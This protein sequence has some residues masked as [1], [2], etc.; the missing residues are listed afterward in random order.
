MF[1]V[2]TA[3]HPARHINI[4]KKV[5]SCLIIYQSTWRMANMSFTIFGWSCHLPLLTIPFLG[6]LNTSMAYRAWP[7]TDISTFLLSTSVY[8]ARKM[9]IPVKFGWFYHQNHMS[10]AGWN[11]CVFDGFPVNHVWLP[12]AKW[13]FQSI[14]I[15]IFM[16]FFVKQFEHELKSLSNNPWSMFAKQLV[17]INPMK[18]PSNPVRRPCRSKCLKRSQS[19]HPQAEGG[20]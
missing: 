12:E 1:F 8:I 13:W 6:V 3:P 5:W 2:L 19:C 14:E 20:A 4:C 18:S 7:N 9:L 11:L 15:H 16:L 10:F 17:N